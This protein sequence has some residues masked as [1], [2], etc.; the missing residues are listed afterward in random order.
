MSRRLLKRP[1]SNIGAA[2]EERKD[3]K[4]QVGSW[5]KASEAINLQ[6]ALY[7]WRHEHI[8]E[9]LNPNTVAEYNRYTQEYN[10]TWAQLANETIERLRRQ[11]EAVLILAATRSYLF[12]SREVIMDKFNIELKLRIQRH[13]ASMD[14]IL[15]S[16]RADYM[17]LAYISEGK[18]HAMDKN[19]S[20]RLDLLEYD[21]KV[22]MEVERQLEWNKTLH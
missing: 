10:Q 22:R 2:G 13:I 14:D 18:A 19:M 4:A 8:S 20:T 12:V 11:F 7:C 1:L 9:K 16:F 5:L 15:Q 21:I 6:W 3:S 17:A